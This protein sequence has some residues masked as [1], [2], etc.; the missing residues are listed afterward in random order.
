MKNL[1]FLGY[2][3][4]SVSED[5]NV[6]SFKSNRFLLGCISNGYHV[7]GL[8]SDA[9]VVKEFFTHRLVGWCYL[10]GFKDGLVINHKQKPTTNNHYKNLEWVT[11]GDNTQYAYDVEE[12]FGK[13]NTPHLNADVKSK[14]IC[15]PYDVTTLS[16]RIRELTEDDIHNICRLFVEGYREI[17]VAKMTG[18]DRRYIGFIKTNECDKWSHIRKLY[19]ISYIKEDRMSPEKVIEICKMLQD[20]GKVLQVSRDTGVNRKKVGNIKN[21]KTFTEISKLY[22]W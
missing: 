5:G 9:G 11:P 6:Y 16:K 17:D 18:F 3:C 1:D 7:V 4:Y 22:S 14:T 15:N 2:S 13:N 21:R 8:T 20:G 10:K 19:N 12:T